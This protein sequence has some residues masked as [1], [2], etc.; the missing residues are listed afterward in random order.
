MRLMALDGG[1]L[2]ECPEYGL[3]GGFLLSLFLFVGRTAL[4]CLDNGRLY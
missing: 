1:E 4:L 2:A 3:W